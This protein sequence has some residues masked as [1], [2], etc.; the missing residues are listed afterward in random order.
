MIQLVA[1]E[2]IEQNGVI[3]ALV[4]IDT[5]IITNLS[6]I[7]PEGP[8]GAHIKSLLLNPPDDGF[9]LIDRFCQYVVLLQDD[10]YTG[11]SMKL[12]DF[13][14]NIDTGL[15]EYQELKGLGW[16]QADIDKIMQIVVDIKDNPSVQEAEIVVRRLPF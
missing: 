13:K 15:E 9:H 1:N 12:S 10:V 5:D 4:V 6:V 7:Y 16:D 11:L 14:G 2:I 8:V 3:H